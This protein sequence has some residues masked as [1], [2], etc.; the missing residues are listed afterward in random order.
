MGAATSQPTF[1]FEYLHNFTHSPSTD[2]SYILHPFPDQNVLALSLEGC[3]AAV[4]SGFVYY[5]RKDVYDRVVLWR[6]P[7]LALWATTTLPALGIST[8]AFTLL[9][10]V[11]S[12]IDTIWSLIYK[13][14]LAKRTAR[15]AKKN[16]GEVSSF[17][18]TSESGIVNAEQPKDPSVPPK[19]EKVKKAMKRTKQ[20]NAALTDKNSA[21]KKYFRDVPALIVNAYDEWGYG[22]HALKT[23]NYGL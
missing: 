2:Q 14:D 6:L 4:G 3:V 13:L 8:Q 15:W 20:V 10:L 17:I 18:F 19:S 23:L 1:N 21:L 7:L 11:A 9:H 16:D 5:S 12:P 22:E